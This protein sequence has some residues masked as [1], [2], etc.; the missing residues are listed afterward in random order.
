MEAG[1]ALRHV[2]ISSFVTYIIIFLY[3][4]V[5]F[6]LTTFPHDCCNA[7]EQICFT[8]IYLFFLLCLRLLGK[9]NIHVSY[10][11]FLL[12]SFSAFLLYDISG[13]VYEVYNYSEF[14]RG[15]GDVLSSD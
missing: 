11:F 4:Y 9:N 1:E 2:Q 10:C 14:W 5:S 3:F 15:K 12:F 6:L 7:R 13:L 8:H